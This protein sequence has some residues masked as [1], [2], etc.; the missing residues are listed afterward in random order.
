MRRLAG[1][2]IAHRVDWADEVAIRRD[3]QRQIEAVLKGVG[4]QLDGNVDIRHL[5]VVGDVGVTAGPARDHV[6]EKLTE[7][8]AQVRQ[9]LQGFQINRLAAAFVIGALDD[10]GEIFRLRRAPG[11][12]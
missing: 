2:Q 4:H 1:E 7:E 6:F 3:E 12:A 10:R 9:R 5:L 11:V 8:E